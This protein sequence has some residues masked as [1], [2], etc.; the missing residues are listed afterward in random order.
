MINF[1][2][3]AVVGGDKILASV[4]EVGIVMGE[5]RRDVVKRN[6]VDA[7]VVEILVTES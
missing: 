3:D 7:I 5:N 1:N 2:F 6:P 4:Q